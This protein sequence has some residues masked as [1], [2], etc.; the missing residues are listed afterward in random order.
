VLPESE[1]L[2]RHFFALYAESDTAGLL[3]LIHPELE[4]VV[5]TTRPGHVLRGR[6]EAAAFLDETAG[7]F[8]EFV[9][10]TYRPLDG[11]RLILEGR[12]R[13]I[14]DERVLRDDPLILALAFRDGL[15]WRSTP[16]QSV[17]EAEAILSAT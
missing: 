16:A 11:E 8:I 3:D 15:L 5:M 4:W 1:R 6:D 2:A 13:W 14:D 17:A 7:R 9:T 12:L 10:E